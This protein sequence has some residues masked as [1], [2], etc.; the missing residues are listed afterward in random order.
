LSLCRE[1][2]KAANDAL[3]RPG[4]ADTSRATILRAAGGAFGPAKT[5]V[6]GVRSNVNSTLQANP[7]ATSS[8]STLNVWPA[9]TEMEALFNN[10]AATLSREVPDNATPEEA[11]AIRESHIA[12][13]SVRPA[14]GKPPTFLSRAPQYALALTANDLAIRPTYWSELGQRYQDGI[15]LEIEKA[16]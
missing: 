6:Q 7:S 12:A 5:G 2:A 3:S 13:C 10:D 4:T 11:A 14:A 15:R 9:E 8:S 1:D 16:V